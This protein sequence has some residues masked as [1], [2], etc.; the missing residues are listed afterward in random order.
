[1]LQS[2]PLLETYNFVVSGFQKSAEFSFFLPGLETA[3]YTAGPYAMDN[4]L[5]TNWTADCMVQ[6]GGCL[7][8]SVGLGIDISFTETYGEAVAERESPWSVSWCFKPLEISRG[9]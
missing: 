8:N 2:P 1:M 9:N 5:W 4:A 3:L 6:L 7:S